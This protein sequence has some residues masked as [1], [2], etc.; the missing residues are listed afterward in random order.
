MI[1][2]KQFIRKFRKKRQKEKRNRYYDSDAFIYSIAENRDIPLQET[3]NLLPTLESI[4]AKG[5]WNQNDFILFRE[6]L[7]T[8]INSLAANV[9]LQEVDFG[10]VILSNQCEAIDMKY[11]FHFCVNLR[12]IT[13]PDATGYEGVVNMDT[14]FCGCS[15]LRE[16]RNFRTYKNIVEM[17]GT[18]RYCSLLSEIEFSNGSLPKGNTKTFQNINREIR[19]IV[20]NGSKIPS[21][22]PQVKAEN[23]IRR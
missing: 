12:L 9:V 16:I 3:G 23:V 18:F 17:Y 11:L 15:K 5:I 8:G 19:V 20:P 22:W 4:E 6:K 14:T 7:K 21:T 10:K 13:L 1:T 2:I